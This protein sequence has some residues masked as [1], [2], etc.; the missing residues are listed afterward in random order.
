M[1]E[2]RKNITQVSS[3]SFLASD[4]EVFCISIHIVQLQAFPF[5]YSSTR[6]FAAL[7]H[8]LAIS[9]HRCHVDNRRNWINRRV[10]GRFD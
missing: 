7:R 10:L 4:A 2:Y 3:C 6:R 5:E 8:W 9:P 1:P